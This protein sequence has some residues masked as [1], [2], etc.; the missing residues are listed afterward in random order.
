MSK[1][2][3]SKSAPPWPES[4][5]LI[6]RLPLDT[7]DSWQAAIRRLP[8]WVEGENGGDPYRP[9]LSL[10][11]SRT[12][13]WILAQR[14]KK[15][16]PSSE[17]FWEVIAEAMLSPIRGRPHRPALVE[18]GSGEL[19]EAIALRLGALG[20]GCA[21]QDD[22]TAMDRSFEALTMPFG[23][24]S[25]FSALVDVRG[26]STDRAGRFFE[27][28]ARFYEAAPWEF[29]PSDAPIRLECPGEWSKPF[30][31]VVIGQ[32]GCPGLCV[33]DDLDLLRSIILEAGSCEEVAARTSAVSLTY[34][35]A[36]EIPVRDLDAAERY[37]WPVVDAEA[38][39][40]A[41]RMLPG[42]PPRAP[43]PHELEVL[44]TCIRAVTE[45]F[46]R[47]AQ[48][49]ALTVHLA[50]GPRTVSLRWVEL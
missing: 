48:P 28:A 13:G 22:I 29:A 47:G 17:S 32:A 4:K 7:D 49:A 43:E 18:V 46:A 41:M 11:T 38:Y 23:R 26:L 27:A 36:V 3:K 42:R 25:G 8:A 2:K 33:Y 5:I 44:E 19:R 6:E 50:S 12:R 35:E 20:V 40:S 45:Y 31:V 14:M 1:R 15:D 10:V 16:F 34:G 24:D 37:G 9:W 39:P 30:F 21:V